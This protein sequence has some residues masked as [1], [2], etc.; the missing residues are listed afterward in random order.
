MKIV[1]K[2]KDNML[3]DICKGCRKKD[4]FCKC[5]T[6]NILNVYSSDIYVKKALRIIIQEGV[7]ADL[8]GNEIVSNINTYIKE[9]L[10][11]EAKRNLLSNDYRFIYKSKSK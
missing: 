6:G 3:V 8:S 9:N 7:V 4:E 2:N 1:K 11:L 5:L 10:V